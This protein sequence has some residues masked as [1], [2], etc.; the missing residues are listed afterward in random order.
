MK[1]TMIALCL[2][3]LFAASAVFVASASAAE[4]PTYK[5]CVAKKGGNYTKG[6]ASES[7]PGK[8]KAELE[9]VE[10]PASFTGSGKKP[11]I[12]IGSK[13]VSCK[14]ASVEGT[15]QYGDGSAGAHYTFTSCGLSKKEPCTTAGESSG[16]I[17]TLRLDTQLNYLNPGETELGIS[18]GLVGAPFA[19]FSCGAG[20]IEVKGEVEG[21]I[22]N[23]KKG[24]TVTYAVSG[25]T[26]EHDTA[27]LEGEEF[28]VG[29]EAGGEPVTLSA[30]LT[31]GPKGVVAIGG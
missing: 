4:A 9:E 8:G 7:A 5:L 24:T 28:T 6:C 10:E 15:I 14:D 31:D 17:K 22:A 1:R 3:A 23:G 27:Y 13:K 25:G 30:T 12:T 2:V 18:A 11:T 26:Q 19:K 20:E 16:T 29:L 21:T